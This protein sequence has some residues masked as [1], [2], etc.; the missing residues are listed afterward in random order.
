MGVKKEVKQSKERM[1]GV[2][3]HMAGD[4][5]VVIWSMGWVIVIL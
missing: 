5:R 4:A 2:K 1:I 3:E